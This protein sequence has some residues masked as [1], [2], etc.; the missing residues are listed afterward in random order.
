M[1][2][3]H[4]K[5]IRKPRLVPAPVRIKLRKPDGDNYLVKVGSGRYCKKGVYCSSE[6]KVEII[7]E[8]VLTLVSLQEWAGSE[9]WKEVVT[10]Y[11]RRKRFPWEDRNLSD[12]LDKRDIDRLEWCDVCGIPTDGEFDLDVAMCMRCSK[13]FHKECLFKHLSTP[14]P[15]DFD[16]EDDQWFC[17]QCRGF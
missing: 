15:R 4:R 17:V 13:C 9:D 12:W 14:L 2:F 16:P 6:E 5:K 7:Q 8:G 11:W 10:V 1:V 3:G